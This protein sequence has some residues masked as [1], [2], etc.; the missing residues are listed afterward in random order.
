MKGI[1]QKFIGEEHRA[2]NIFFPGIQMTCLHWSARAAN[3]AANSVET[4]NRPCRT[5]FLICRK[6]WYL[7]RKEKETVSSHEIYIF[8]ICYFSPSSSTLTKSLPFRIFMMG[9]L[10]FFSIVK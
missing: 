9:G 7:L 8:S 4:G 1:L 3:S 5:S 2:L 10:L 6:N